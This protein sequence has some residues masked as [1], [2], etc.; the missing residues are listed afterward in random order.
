MIFDDRSGTPVDETQPIRK[1][2][3]EAGIEDSDQECFR[4]RTGRFTIGMRQMIGERMNSPDAS[5]TELSARTPRPSS[6]YC[7]SVQR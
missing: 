6:L 7:F 2:A 3:V 5:A 4:D 1:I